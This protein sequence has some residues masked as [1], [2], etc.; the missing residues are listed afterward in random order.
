MSPDSYQ[1]PQ[2]S[3]KFVQAHVYVWA[4]DFLQLEARAWSYEEFVR[5]KLW[6]WVNPQVTS[7]TNASSVHFG[8]SMKKHFGMDDAYVNTN[9]GECASY[10]VSQL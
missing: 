1:L 7:F 2:G 8:H 6:R 5:E 10:R 4:H 3:E 9:H